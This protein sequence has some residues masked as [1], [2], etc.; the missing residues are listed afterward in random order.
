MKSYGFKLADFK[1]DLAKKFMLVSN[2]RYFEFWS[3]FF[4]VYVSFVRVKVQVLSLI[5]L[6]PLFFFS[7]NHCTPQT[8]VHYMYI[9]NGIK[10]D[11]NE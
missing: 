5:F 10:T 9:V 8:E 3:F 4:T 11:W 2:H 7:I 1:V 6:L